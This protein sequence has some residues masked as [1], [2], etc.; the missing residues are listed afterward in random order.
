M[1]WL[2]HHTRSEKLA[3][4][5]EIAARRGHVKRA[6]QLYSDA[7]KA[8]ELALNDVESGKSRTLGITVVSAVSLYYKAAGFQ[9]AETL[10]CR[11]LASGHLPA[12]ATEQ[13]RGL[14]DGAAPAEL[15]E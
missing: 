4:D 2:Q 13:L 8:E 11:W 1:S 14:Y 15:A 12:F 10:A 9:A 5:A 3:A 7:A 6:M